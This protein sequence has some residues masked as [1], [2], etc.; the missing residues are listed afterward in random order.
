M[1]RP[2]FGGLSLPEEMRRLRVYTH[3]PIRSL[4]ARRVSGL[5]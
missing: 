1:N 3:V 4:M 5:N 2:H